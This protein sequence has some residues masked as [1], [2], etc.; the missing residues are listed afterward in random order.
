MEKVAAASAAYCFLGNEQSKIYANKKYG[1]NKSVDNKTIDKLSLLLFANN[2]ICDID[3]CLIDY[4]IKQLSK[5]CKDCK[6]KNYK[7]PLV[8]KAKDYTEW[9]NSEMYKACLEKELLEKG[10]V[11]IAEHIEKLCE[12]FKFKITPNKVCDL[13]KTTI[14]TNKIDCVNIAKIDFNKVCNLLLS[15][16]KAIETCSISKTEI[17]SAKACGIDISDVAVNTL[18]DINPIKIAEPE[19]CKL[20][21]NILTNNVLWM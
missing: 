10:Y 18:C 6:P 15:D 9:Y 21:T 14:Q 13:I 1:I 12:G 16:L 5:Y 17:T 19:I 20:I 3:K 4:K 7:T 2:S 8:E 11:E